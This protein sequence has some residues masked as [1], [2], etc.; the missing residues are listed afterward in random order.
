[1]YK[2]YGGNISSQRPG[3]PANLFTYQGPRGIKVGGQRASGA[4]RLRT[5]GR[6][7]RM[8]RTGLLACRQSYR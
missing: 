8:A 7:N 2:L 3:D 1:V 4:L 6:A 5:Q